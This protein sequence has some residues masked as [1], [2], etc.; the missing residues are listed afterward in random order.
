MAFA[1]RYNLFHSTSAAAVVGT[2]ERH[3]A[4]LG[5]HVQTSPCRPVGSRY[6]Q[7]E[8]LTLEVYATDTG[9]VIVDLP[10]GWDLAARRVAH[11]SISEQLQCTGMLVFA[12]DGDVWGYELFTD[13]R[14]VDHFIQDCGY[15]D[16]F[17]PGVADTSGDAGRLEELFPFVSEADVRPY[18]V[19]APIPNSDADGDLAD[20]FRKHDSLDVTRSQVSSSTRC[21]TWVLGIAVMSAPARIPLAAAKRRCVRLR[22]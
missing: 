6:G 18:L 21:N 17:F 22:H 4:G 19:R 9:W 3:Y 14:S 13:G 16:Q 20:C 12:Y 7:L 1:L 15:A 11:A 10:T 8:A 5:A 2:I